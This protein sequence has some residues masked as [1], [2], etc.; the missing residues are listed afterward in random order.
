ME[1]EVRDQDTDDKEDDNEEERPDEAAS[2]SS[3]P[4]YEFW[5]KCLLN[6]VCMG[7]KSNAFGKF[8]FNSSNE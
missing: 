5:G 7:T 4:L 2:I 3:P 8:P 6:K 1:K